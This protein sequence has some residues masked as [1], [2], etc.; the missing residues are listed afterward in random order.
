MQ[1]SNET[2]TNSKPD[3]ELTVREARAQYFQANGFGEN[4]GY[5]D[6]W[7]YLKF[8]WLRLPVYNSAARRRAVPLHDLHHIATGFATDPKGEAQVAI[9]EIAAGTYDKWFALMINVP[10]LIYGFVLW[11]KV[12]ASA[13]RLGRHSSSLYRVDFSDALLD[14]SV[15]ELKERTLGRATPN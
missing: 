5:Q 12:A 11:P 3:T 15:A 2:Q 13:W 9:W 1:S 10:A 14:L 8:G 7:V 4:G 6:K